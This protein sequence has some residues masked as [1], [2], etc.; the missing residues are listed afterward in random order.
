M[1]RRHPVLH[2]CIASQAY[3][4][5][6]RPAPRR[7]FSERFRSRSPG[8][9]TRRVLC[10]IGTCPIS[11][12]RCCS[13]LRE[14]IFV[15]DYFRKR[16]VFQNLFRRHLL[17]LGEF[18]TCARSSWAAGM[19]QPHTKAGRA[20]PCPWGGASVCGVTPG[21]AHGDKRAALERQVCPQRVPA[22][23]PASRRLSLHFVFQPSAGPAQP[24]RGVRDTA[25][26]HVLDTAEPLTSSPGPSLDAGVPTATREER[27]VARAV[28]AVCAGVGTRSGR[29]L[30][31]GPRP[32]GAPV[33]KLLPQ[34]DVF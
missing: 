26:G 11:P 8:V 1:A 16:I 21:S 19:W 23:V 27:T 10:G 18:D 30:R 2:V 31:G 9:F 29:R 34:V 24:H 25:A 6:R 4:G 13:S 14:S 28:A 22:Q 20:G 17:R 12:R 15:S 32:D 3:S 5:D 7:A 33:V